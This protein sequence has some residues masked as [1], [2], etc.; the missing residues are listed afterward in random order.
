MRSF[1]WTMVLCA[2][3][4]VLTPKPALAWFEFLDY[5]SGPGPFTGARVDF[6]VWC[7]RRTTATGQ[8]IK[9]AHELFAK[10]LDK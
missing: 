3:M 9:E 4:L 2:A 6:R 1:K 5:L 7:F 10:A 8:A